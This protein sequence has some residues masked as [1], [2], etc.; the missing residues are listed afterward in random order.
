MKTT[1]SQF[2][3]IQLLALRVLKPS[4]SGAINREL[5][6]R[7]TPVRKATRSKAA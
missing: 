7:A 5:N 3:G 1:L 4:A 2:S 6:N